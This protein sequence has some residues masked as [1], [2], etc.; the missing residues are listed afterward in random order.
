MDLNIFRVEPACS[1][2]QLANDSRFYV[3]EWLVAHTMP[4]IYVT[5]ATHLQP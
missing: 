3:K 4:H 1:R 5:E 2:Q